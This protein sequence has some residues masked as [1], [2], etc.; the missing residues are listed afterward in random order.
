MIN[1]DLFCE[2]E[3]LRKEGKSYSEIKSKLGIS[4]ST[5]SDWFSDKEWSSLVKTKIN[6]KYLPKNMKRIILMN[7]LRAIKKIERDN[8][9]LLESDLEYKKMKSNPLFIA[10]L[11][12]YWGEGEKYG[13]SRIAVINTEVKMILIMINFITLILKVP[14][15]VIKAGLFIYDDL[16][17]IS[18]QK[19][20]AKLLGLRSDQFIKTHILHSRARP[21]KKKSA[22]GM[23]NIYVCRTELKLKVM[24]WIELF[25]LEYSKKL[26]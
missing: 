15:N 1:K 25:T 10:G 3:K 6:I 2:A 20:W 13:T 24:R 14:K 16:D 5:L 11:M 21:G 22:H 9:Y 23:C 17:V 26:I 4:K 7:K 19:Y 8:K 18:V 12:I